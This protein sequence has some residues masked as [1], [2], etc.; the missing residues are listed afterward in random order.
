MT[1][2]EKIEWLISQGVDHE[3]AHAFVEIEESDDPNDIVIVEKAETE[4]SE[5]KVK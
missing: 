3:R 4:D 5:E 2:E 1:R